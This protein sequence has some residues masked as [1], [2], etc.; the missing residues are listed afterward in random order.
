MRLILILAI[1]CALAFHPAFAQTL[2]T[3]SAS[4]DRHVALYYD[5]LPSLPLNEGYKLYF[6]NTQSLLPLSENLIPAERTDYT[7]DAAMDDME[8]GI[9]LGEIGS[10]L[11]ASRRRVL[12]GAFQYFVT[13]SP[14][15]QW[16]SIEGGAHKFWR[17][18]IYHQVDG[19]FQRVALPSYKSFLDYFDDRKNDLH[20]ADLGATATIHKIEPHD[21]AHACW[22][23]NGV[24][25]INA[26]PYLLSDPAYEKRETH[27][28]FFL[29][30]ARMNPATITGFC[31]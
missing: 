19:R 29:L 16:V 26:Y 23:Q 20:V 30:D 1:V 8:S 21:Q 10:L 6:R 27:N 18:M 3:Q 22:L 17:T 7:S 31:Q 5:H 24:P 12:W 15:S 28:L 14:D 4:P 9:L 25:A 2:V 13:W 11:E